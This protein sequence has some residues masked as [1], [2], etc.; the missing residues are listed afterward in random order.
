MRSFQLEPLEDRR[1]LSICN[2]PLGNTPASATQWDLTETLQG[3]L[4]EVTG[5]LGEPA[6]SFIKFQA[7]ADHLYT[8]DSQT[9]F[10]LDIRAADGVTIIAKSS[11]VTGAQGLNR[12][13]WTAPQSG[14][15]YLT[16]GPYTGMSTY[17]TS[18]PYTISA[19]ITPPES[20][21]ITGTI[22]TQAPFHGELSQP[23]EVDLI[24]FEAK[25]NTLY[26]FILPHDPNNPTP[27]EPTDQPVNHL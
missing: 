17:I 10:P 1:F 8:F 4:R 14:N 16:V 21:S 3:N 12:M 23:G 9:S 15:Y 7:K 13:F 5:P 11:V 25:E 22:S 19:A 6:H 27:P 2:P 24:E 26:K 18:G 20:V